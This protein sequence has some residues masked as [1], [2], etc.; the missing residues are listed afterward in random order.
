MYIPEIYQV[1]ILLRILKS[2][3]CILNFYEFCTESISS[4][5]IKAEM[6]NDIYLQVE[7]FL[8][9]FWHKNFWH[10]QM[11]II[12]HFGFCHIRRNFG[13]GQLDL[14]KSKL[15]RYVLLKSIYSRCSN[16]KIK[17][18]LLQ[19]SGAKYRAKINV[20]FEK[21]LFYIFFAQDLNP[22]PGMREAAQPLMPLE[23]ALEAGVLSFWQFDCYCYSGLF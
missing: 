17:C 12:C 19:S 16:F 11:N 23:A 5:M 6:S 21:F 14:S 20:H 7:K 4:N 13:L 9:L 22:L 15:S 10:L 1:K 3:V 2:L 18:K 8:T